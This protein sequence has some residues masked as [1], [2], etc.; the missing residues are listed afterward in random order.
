MSDDNVLLETKRGSY[1]S[2]PETPR[3]DKTRSGET[4]QRMQSANFGYMAEKYRT[5]FYSHVRA[6]RLLLAERERQV[7]WEEYNKI[8]MNSYE[9][10]LIVQ[11]LD[12]EALCKLYGHCAK[13]FRPLGELELAS[14]YNDLVQRE[15]APL[16]VERLRE[17][18]RYIDDMIEDSRD[19]LLED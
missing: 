3:G 5:D 19:A 11:N 2:P 9:Q 14:D 10:K 7:T 15:L 16:L 17:A 6:D 18:S 12:N 1:N 4:R 8:T 13:Q